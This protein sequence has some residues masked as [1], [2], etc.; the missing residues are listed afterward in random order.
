MAA[1]LSDPRHVRLV[2]WLTTPPSLREPST[3][4]EL[5]EELG[6]AT[7]TLRDWQTKPEVRKA[8]EVRAVEVA[9]EPDR[10]QRVLDELYATA[11]DRTSRGHVAAAK[12]YLEAVDAIKPP[13]QSV[14]VRGVRSVDELSDAELEALIAEEAVRLRVERGLGAEG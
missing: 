11:T 2:E 6:V 5:A 8:W 12:L 14:T 13:E 10:V 4:Q 1:G 9:G 7:R 3:K